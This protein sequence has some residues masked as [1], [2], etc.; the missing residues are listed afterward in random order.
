MRNILLGLSLVLMLGSVS[1]AAIMTDGMGRPS[2]ITDFDVSGTLYDVTFHFDDLSTANDD[3]ATF[4]SNP[5][6]LFSSGQFNTIAT[7]IAGMITGVANAD[8]GLEAIVI[9]LATIPSTNNN[10]L[11]FDS[12]SRVRRNFGAGS[13]WIGQEPDIINLTDELEAN[14]GSAVFSLAASSGVPEPSSFAL[15]G[16]ATLGGVVVYRR[17]RRENTVS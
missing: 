16:M 8:S 1:D 11:T 7:S 17:R 5:V 14:V 2:L 9:H 10:A 12:A 15:L 4:A 3:I 6:A 13:T